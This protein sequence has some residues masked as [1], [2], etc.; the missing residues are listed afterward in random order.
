MLQRIQSIYLLLVVALMAVTTFS[1]LLSLHGSGNV[2]Q[3]MYSCGIYQAGELM[4][5]TWGVLSMAGLSALV[6]FINIFLFKKRKLQIK[7]GMLT[8]FLLIL[9]YVAAGAY[10][11]VY[12][13]RMA[14]EFSGAYYGIILP[15][16]ALILNFMAIGRIKKD[17]KLVR[18]LDRIR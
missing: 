5:P 1:P 9:F 7:L 14:L 4:K 12:S 17:E 16:V 15:L 10:F 13:N 6:A 11:Y 3:D 2:M 8:A 18:S